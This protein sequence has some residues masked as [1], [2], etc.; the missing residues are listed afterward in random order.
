MD[1]LY[2]ELLLYFG[3]VL[4]IIK[5]N[6]KA[7]FFL[8][9][10][11]LTLRYANSLFCLSATQQ[12]PKTVRQ[13][14]GLTNNRCIVLHNLVLFLI[15]LFQRKG[16]LSLLTEKVNWIHYSLP[17]QC[18]CMAKILHFLVFVLQ[19]LVVP[20]PPLLLRLAVLSTHILFVILCSIWCE[21]FLGNVINIIVCLVS[22]SNFINCLK[23]NH[24]S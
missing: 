8:F 1:I 6:L 2:F 24:V 11:I 21:H 20:V 18:R 13:I 10:C 5:E 14:P 4:N 23:N 9:Y 16:I 15:F 3:D 12:S 19:L 7:I 17:P 22:L